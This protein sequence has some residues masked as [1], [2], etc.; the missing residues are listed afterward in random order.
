MKKNKIFN[1]IIFI[2]LLFLILMCNIVYADNIEDEIVD[3]INIT[4]KEIKDTKNLKINSKNV[5][6][7]DRK[8]KRILYGR[9]ENERVSMASTTKIMTSIILVENG[10]LNDK[11]K[12]SKKAANT[13]GSRLGLKENDEIIVKDLLYGL[14]LRS[15]NDAA[16]AIAEYISG[17]VSNFAKLMNEKA[18]KLGLE[19]TNFVT[20]HGLDDINH[21]TT[22]YE[23]SL[24][25]DY[26][27]NNEV[28]LNVVNTK[29]YNIIINESVKNINNTN[30]LLGTLNGVYGVKTGFTNNAGRCLVTAVKRND[31]DIISVV[32][33]ADTKKDRTK[34]SIN[35]ITYTYDNYNNVNIK[36]NLKNIFN[37]WYLKNKDKIKIIKGKSQ[38]IELYI[39]ENK[40]IIPL[41]KNEENNISYDIILHTYN[42]LSPVYENMEIGK[43][44][45]KLD[46]QII[47]SERI[48]V[49]NRILSKD[50]IDY[51]K[52]YT[53]VFYDGS[54]LN[55]I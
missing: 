52:M 55:N 44:N 4:D 43:I 1:I 26:A 25:T 13:G 54:I 20:P 39:E 53:K 3:V 19:N 9:N 47:G 46:N 11:V 38:N 37:E 2:I 24:I 35:L 51:L 50:I 12:I 34:D 30:E 14:M 40:E 48:L 31:L 22:A 49:K 7:I 18:K 21:Y 32:L 41:L 29:N 16:V 45:I 33:G 28:I 23:L 17:N 5:V 42:I 10:N 6:V 8:S 27:L 15:G 36:S